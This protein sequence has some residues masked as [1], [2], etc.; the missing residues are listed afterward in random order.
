MEVATGELQISY[1]KENNRTAKIHVD[2]GTKNPKRHA[3]STQEKERASHASQWY[4]INRLE[5]DLAAQ[6]FRMNL[7]DES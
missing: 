2:V 3:L 1:Q 7:P 5:F 6:C 4:L